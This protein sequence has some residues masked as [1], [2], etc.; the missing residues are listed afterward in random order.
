LATVKTSGNATPSVLKGNVSSFFLPDWSPTGEWITYHDDRDWELISPDASTVKSLGDIRTYYLA[1]SKD[2]KKLYGIGPEEDKAPLFEVDLATL[3]TKAIK[4]LGAGWEPDEDLLPA[5]RLS[6][7]PDGKSLAYAVSKT[8]EN[9][10]MLQG[11]RQPGLL[12]RIGD[13]INK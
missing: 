12:E 4:E 6:L 13:F 8:Q 10:W 5:I 2:G 7:A 9:I 11:Y 3:K 1:F